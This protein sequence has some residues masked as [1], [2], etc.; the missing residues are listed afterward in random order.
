MLIFGSGNVVHN[1]SRVDWRMNDGQPWAQ[2]FDQYIHRAVTNGRHQ[3]V[4]D[5]ANDGEPAQLS[6]PSIDH[7][8]PLLYVLGASDADD[9]VRVINA[10]CT[11]GSMSMTSY[12]FS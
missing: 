11:L 5:F 4:I 12:L 8:A 3:D 9:Q 7:F 6:V 2:E 1:L 10:D